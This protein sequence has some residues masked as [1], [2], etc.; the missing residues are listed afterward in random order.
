[1]TQYKVEELLAL[2]DSVSESAVSIEKLDVDESVKGQSPF[3]M[4][5]ANCP[6]ASQGNTAISNITRRCL[7]YCAQLSRDEGMPASD[8]DELHEHHQA[9]FDSPFPASTSHFSLSLP[10]SLSLLISSPLQ[11]HSKKTSLDQIITRF[12]SPSLSRSNSDIMPLYITGKGSPVRRIPSLTSSHIRLIPQHSRRFTDKFLEEHVLRPSSSVNCMSLKSENIPLDGNSKATRAVS[13]PPRCASQPVKEQ[14]FGH[15]AVKKPSPTPSI[16]RGKAERLLKEHASPPGMRVTAGGRVVPTD[17]TSFVAPVPPFHPAAR[18]HMFDMRAGKPDSAHQ[19]PSHHSIPQGFIGYDI[20]GQL[21]QKVGDNLLPVQMINGLPHFHLPPVNNFPAIPAMSA[22]T[23]PPTGQQFANQ[24]GNGSLPAEPASV[25]IDEHITHLENHYKLLDKE[26]QQFERFEVIEK[27]RAPVHMQRQLI[28][29]KRWYITELDRIRRAAKQVKEMKATGAVTVPATFGLEA[30]HSAPAPAPPQQH[31]PGFMFQGMPQQLAAPQA[32]PMF[33]QGPVMHF[34]VPQYGPVRYDMPPH[35]FYLPNGMQPG[36]QPGP[37]GF[38]PVNGG[39]PVHNFGP[40]PA[41]PNGI[42]QAKPLNPEQPFDADQPF[43]RGNNAVEIKDPLERPKQDSHLDPTSPSYVPKNLAGTRK[44][45]SL[46]HCDPGTPTPVGS[47]NDG[48]PRADLAKYLVGDDGD[49]HHGSPEIPSSAERVN[50]KSSQSSVSTSAFFPVNTHEYST[51]TLYG[52]RSGANEENIPFMSSPNGERSAPGVPTNTPAPGVEAAHSK[53]GSHASAQ[54]HRLSSWTRESG[55]VMDLALNNG[56]HDLRAP[57]LDGPASESPD[58]FFTVQLSSG[59][60]DASEASIKSLDLGYLDGWQTDYRPTEV[61]RSSKYREQF[62]RALEARRR[63]RE[64]EQGKRKDELSDAELIK[65]GSRPERLLKSEEYWT[66][67][68]EGNHA[69]HQR[70]VENTE[71]PIPPLPNAPHLS[72]RRFALTEPD[73]N[74]ETLSGLPSNVQG[75]TI[76]ASEPPKRTYAGP[77]QPLHAQTASEAQNASNVT[78]NGISAIQP[79]NVQANMCKPTKSKHCYRSSTTSGRTRNASRAVSAAIRPYP[80]N[81]A[82]NDPLRCKSPTSPKISN[83]WPS[84]CDGAVDDLARELSHT[85]MTASG[86]STAPATTLNGTINQDTAFKSPKKDKGSATPSP[87]KK[88]KGS[89]SPARAK[90]EQIANKVK[91]FDKRKEKGDKE[92]PDPATMDPEQ[93]EKH[94]KAWRK[95]FDRVRKEQS[96]EIRKYHNGQRNSNG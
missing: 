11:T 13:G 1:M 3:G 34:E 86:P 28:E 42:A 65:S 70:I 24:F 30:N 77:T 33:R 54:D 94:R 6:H 45:S 67:F 83:G 9:R 21:C 55:Q 20:K 58:R 85:T 37:G 10:A 35:G 40:N 56:N 15:L 75:N 26:R 84:Q 89:S 90:L 16:K 44:E 93:K 87:S 7:F 38:F 29:K 52:A 74:I 23:A 59:R 19:A 81:M 78:T 39:M 51:K 14:V 80:G 17:F 88:E 18:G 48:L 46:K 4:I 53:D 22:P 43:S 31:A 50:K 79:I 27:E 32:H 68:E 82:Y 36:M 60:S 95:R 91:N 47:P 41:E 49:N 2:R 12:V 8:L 92:K 71:N 76:T 61:L 63:L 96:E 66:A 64:T 72:P 73:S 62:G 57:V 69:R 5:P 25:N